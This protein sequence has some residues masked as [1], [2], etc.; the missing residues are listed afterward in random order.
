MKD[1]WKAKT[2]AKDLRMVVD[3]CDMNK[4]QKV[5]LHIRNKWL[6]LNISSKTTVMVYLKTVT[7]GC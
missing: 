7:K 1:D 5:D 4:T 6:I 3:A 2:H